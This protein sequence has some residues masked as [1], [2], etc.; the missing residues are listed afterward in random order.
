MSISTSGL[1]MC[2]SC[3]LLYPV[4]ENHLCSPGFE[5]YER[6]GVQDDNDDDDDD[7]DN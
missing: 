1:S 3:K 6:S 5:L 4:A 7:D 2:D